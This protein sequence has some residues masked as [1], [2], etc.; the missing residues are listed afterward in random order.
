M[1][2]QNVIWQY[3]WCSLDPIWNEKV[4]DIYHPALCYPVYG[5]MYSTVGSIGESEMTT[6]FKRHKS[7]VGH[8]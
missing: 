3:G 4:T 8:K 1:A 7:S 2:D 5:E 6:S